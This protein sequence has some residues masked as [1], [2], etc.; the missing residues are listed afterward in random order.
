[1]PLAGWLLASWLSLQTVDVVQSCTHGRPTYR[2]MNPFVFENCA[3]MVP[4]VVALDAGTIWLTQKL[5]K[6]WK[7]AVIYGA[8]N[9]VEIWAV[10]HNARVFA[11]VKKY[12]R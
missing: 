5:D 2:E 3:L 6:K 9:G 12:G 1:M 11:Q 4:E 7:R 10:Q 8:L